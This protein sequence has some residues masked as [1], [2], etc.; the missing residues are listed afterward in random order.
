MKTGVQI[1]E[2]RNQ[3]AIYQ[4]NPDELVLLGHQARRE[5]ELFLNTHINDPQVGWPR[6]LRRAS[7]P[8]SYIT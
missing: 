1:Q 6:V 2:A 4:T 8:S 5:M 3:H 7:C